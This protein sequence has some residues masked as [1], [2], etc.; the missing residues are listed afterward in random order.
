[1][2]EYIGTILS[3]PVLIEKIITV[4]YFEYTKN[5]AFTGEVHDFWEI[6][7]A[8]KGDLYITAGS[9]ELPL[10]QGQMYI[11]RPM[12][13]HNVRCDGRKA[14]NSVIVTFSCTAPALFAV[15]GSVICCGD[16]TRDLL[17]AIISE[18]KKSFSGPLGD[19]Y[20]LCLTRRQDAVF[21]SEQLIKIYLELLLIRLIRSKEPTGRITNLP[22]SRGD[23]RRVNEICVYLEQNCEKNISFSEICTEFSLSASV[24][25]KLFAAKLG[26]GAM[27]FFSNCKIE[28]AKQLIREDSRNITEIAERLSYSSVYYFS[29]A[30]KK[31]VGMTPTQYAASVKAMYEEHSVPIPAEDSP[32]NASLLP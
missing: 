29:R 16:S 26:C 14:S 3:Q 12:E 19:P 11:H 30:F 21:G 9:S 6:V 13:F 32:E 25:K 8:D 23:D 10:R 20:T 4:H 24:V 5:F 2:T 15:A 7:F 1:M 27:E 17:A 31:A 18:A 28:R 22:K